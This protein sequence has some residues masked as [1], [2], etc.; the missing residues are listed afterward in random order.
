MNIWHAVDAK[1]ITPE[2]FV[3]CIEISAGSKNKYELDKQTGALILDRILF[4]ATHYP[5]NYGFIPHTLSEDG[6]PLDVLVICSEPIV[7]L[8]LTPAYPIGLLEMNDTGQLDEKIIAICAHDPLY[9]DYKDIC[10]LPSHVSE[11]IKHFFTVYKE[12]EYGKH[13]EVKEIKGRDAAKE[14]IKKDIEAYERAFP[15]QK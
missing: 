6:D 8:A 11:E 15:S 7:P 10:Q 9:N 12:L 4:T 5:Q 2:Q 13:T 14:V 1:R 3:A